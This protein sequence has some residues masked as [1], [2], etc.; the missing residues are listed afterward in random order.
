MQ[1]IL[2]LDSEPEICDIIAESLRL[3]GYRTFSSPSGRRGVY[4]LK[5][6]KIALVIGSSDLL[7]I[8]YEGFVSEMGAAP[9]HPRFIRIQKKPD[10]QYA[11]LTDII[12]LPIE[13]E[14]LC[15]L[16]ERNIMKEG[17][18]KPK[19]RRKLFIAA[20]SVLLFSAFIYFFKPEDRDQVRILPTSSVSGI[21]FEDDK[22]Y[23]ADWFDRVI[24]VLDKSTVLD[25][26]KGKG[27]PPQKVDM[28]KYSLIGLAVFDN[29]YWITDIDKKSIIRLD[30]SETPALLEK[31]NAPGPSP[32][33][34]FS[35]G[36]GMWTADSVYRKI[37]RHT[38]DSRFAVV[39]VISPEVGYLAGFFILKD[40]LYVADGD[41]NTLAE[42][43]EYFTLKNRY[44]MKYYDSKT[45]IGAIA[46]DG[47]R[48]YSV[49]EGSDRLVIHS[50]SGLEKLKKK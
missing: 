2:I 20:V 43:D 8:G 39:D 45:R 34:L 16:V 28:K 6:R 25:A 4:I 42:H 21:W 40:K 10:E 32:S 46:T 1:N 18:N 3:K 26:R 35:D 49:P 22:I 23:L 36:Q 19:T 9:G 24:Y 31:H 7:D 27:V 30:M 13:D 29:S 38:A 15:E 50:K 12:K 41:N 37:Y 17:I 44:R 48:I 14:K 33:A 47:K 5:R 11:S